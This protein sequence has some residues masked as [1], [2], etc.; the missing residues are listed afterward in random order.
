MAVM[1]TSAR[2]TSGPPQEPPTQRAWRAWVDAE[3]ER[4][5]LCTER[6]LRRQQHLSMR[7][8]AAPE[9]ERMLAFRWRRRHPGESLQNAN[10]PSVLMAEL[11]AALTEQAPRLSQL[12][13]YALPLLLRRLGVS[14]LE[15]DAL[16]VIA[17]P[18]L[19]PALSDLFACLRGSAM[20]RRGVDLALIAQLLGLKNATR[21][22]MHSLFDEERP[23]RLGRLIEI[24]AAQD[25][26]SSTGYRAIQPTLDLLWV[27]RGHEGTVSPSLRRHASVVTAAP[28]L[29]GLL[30]DQVTLDWLLPL[31]ERFE[32]SGAAARPASTPPL[33]WSILWGARGSGKRELAARLAARAGRALVTLDPAL[34]AKEQLVDQVR[35]AVRDAAW[36]DAALHVG[37]LD[38]AVL[39]EQPALLRELERAQ[40]PVFLGFEGS[41][42]PRLATRLP[43]AE[44]ALPVLT[45][46]TR[47]ALWQRELPATALDAHVDLPAIARSYKIPA[48]EILECAREALSL[49][50]DAQVTSA[51]LRGLMERRMRNEL[52]AVATRVPVS[53][54]WADVILP[55]EEQARIGEFIARKRHEDLVY[56]EW[57]LDERIGYGK[58][59]IG[60]FSGPPGTGKT[61]L[62]GLVARE[63]GLE[64]YQIDLSQIFS[65]WLGE[66]E[67]ALGKVF[68][69]A[70]RSH[71][72]LL[73]DEADALLAKRTS[74]GDSH[75]RYANAA[76]NYLLQRL[77]RYSGVAILTTNKDAS[78]DD[79]LAR[80]LSLHLKLGEPAAP[81]RL[82]LWRKHLPLRVPGADTV[83]LEWLAS[84]FSLTGGYIK[85]VAVRATFLAAAE[86]TP[87][88]TDLV[89]R[90]A[91]LELEDMGRVVVG[92][93]TTTPYSSDAWLTNDY[94][95]G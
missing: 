84:E 93:P 56:R 50:G 25:V 9:I 16:L 10:D 55:A 74:V 72:V 67:K 42:P 32:R 70:E 92:D 11:D 94:V 89:R 4:I 64:L 81:E 24:A 2:P 27:L 46:P 17:A 69:Q 21:L 60:L 76:V 6:E 13:A 95:E 26:F 71:A 51:T 88:S 34:I 19:D 14:P 43:V 35:R 20:A 31:A 59:L 41:T 78:L 49:A 15:A 63:L 87:L 53:V 40:L 12:R 68:D 36:L 7:P 90:A 29:D 37:P 66:T 86:A 8:A 22:D 61:L 85:N 18:S 73:F 57:G 80:R 23:M 1:T 33:P 58:G 30:L 3:L 83:D 52:T 28:N 5:W 54:T 91:N 65:R 82:E 77:E 45:A 47:L 75:D 79:A 39:R 44:L 48:G 38:E 62:A